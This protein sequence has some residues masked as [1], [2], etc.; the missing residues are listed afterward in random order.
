MT[1]KDALLI[2]GGVIVGAALAAEARRVRRAIDLEGRT[3]LVTGG[4]RG[5][6]LLIARELGRQ[7][8]KVVLLARDQAELERAE[9]R[10]RAEG[11]DASIGRRPTSRT[12]RRPS[13]PSRPW[14]AAMAPSTCSSTTP[15]SSWSVRSIT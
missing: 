6:G 5:L 9:R 13:A 2:A 15:A 14:S 7:G 11:I 4:S 8:A 12:G 3:A 10:L 1:G